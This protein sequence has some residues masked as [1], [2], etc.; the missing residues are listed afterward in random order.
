MATASVMEKLEF[1]DIQGILIS[2]YSN[3]PCA[4]YLMCE[5]VDPA[6]ARIWL[7]RVVPRI[8]D[9]TGPDKVSSMNIAFTA[10]G[11]GTLGLDRESLS[12]FPFAFSEGMT[13]EYRSRILGDSGENHPRNWI[14]GGPGTR[15]VHIL[16]MVFARD[17]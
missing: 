6:A 3:L 16:L 1:D 5:I 13:P 7:Q 8:K 11:L 14:W 17:E 12:T 2:A 10:E 9:A 15:A 4:A